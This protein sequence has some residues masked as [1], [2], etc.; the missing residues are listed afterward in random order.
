[1]PLN[2]HSFDCEVG[3]EANSKPTL[4]INIGHIWS[5]KTDQCWWQIKKGWERRNE[6]LD[7]FLSLKQFSEHVLSNIYLARKYDFF[8]V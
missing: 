6:Y 1:M 7:N 8:K 4:I 3:G 5:F 2:Q